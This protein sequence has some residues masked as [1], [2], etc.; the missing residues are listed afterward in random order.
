MGCA[1]GR[2]KVSSEDATVADIRRVLI[3]KF[4]GIKRDG[5]G[6]RILVTPPF[7]RDQKIVTFFEKPNVRYY[8]RVFIIG[9]RLPYD[10]EVEVA[11]ESKN[12]TDFVASG[13]DVQLAEEVLQDIKTRIKSRKQNRPNAIEEFRAF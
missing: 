6:G 2:P 5:S 13:F 1:S 9:D 11:V 12:E 7:H 10:L 3:E 8:A 4:G